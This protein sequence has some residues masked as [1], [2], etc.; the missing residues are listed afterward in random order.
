MF[1]LTVY[2]KFVFKNSESIVN[3]EMNMLVYTSIQLEKNYLF[4]FILYSF[5][6]H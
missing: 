2:T 3:A 5:Y 1:V 6:I 4:Y